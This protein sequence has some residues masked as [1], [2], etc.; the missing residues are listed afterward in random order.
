[1]CEK[2]LVLS[3][4]KRAIW[5]KICIAF[6]AFQK[7]INLILSVVHNACVPTKSCEASRLIL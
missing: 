1:V 6:E 2:C 3:L 5:T 7:G 4:Y